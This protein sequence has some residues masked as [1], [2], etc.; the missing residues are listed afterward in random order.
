MSKKYLVYMYTNTI[1]SKKYVGV[2]CD[3]LEKR[4]GP[5]G[6][7]YKGCPRFFESIRKY[8]WSSFKTQV[9]HEG[10]TKQEAAELEKGLIV[11]YSTLDRTLGYNLHKGGFENREYNVAREAKRIE[12]ISSTLKKQR[13]DTATR[14]LMSK[15]MSK[16]WSDPD[17]RKKILLS[18]LGC[19]SGRPRVKIECRDT[20]IV[21]NSQTE[22]ALSL[23]IKESTM[24]KRLKN[25]QAFVLFTSKSDTNPYPSVYLRKCS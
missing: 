2:T 12:R 19:F 3:T 22:A 13:S 14:Q 7:Q 4:A 23:G 15:R 20:G 5:E 1:N 6:C 18:R 17:K 25:T 8:G 21:Y 10:L 24:S 11:K 9:L 16:V